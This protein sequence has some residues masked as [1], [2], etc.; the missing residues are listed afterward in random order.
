MSCLRRA[1]GTD[2]LGADENL[3][4]G[5]ARGIAQNGCSVVV[6]PLEVLS[7][8]KKSWFGVQLPPWCF[9]KR[10]VDQVTCFIFEFSFS[11]SSGAD[12]ARVP[13]EA[14]IARQ[15]AHNSRISTSPLVLAWA[16]HE[17]QDIYV[18]TSLGLNN[19]FLPW[20]IFT[21][22]PTVFAVQ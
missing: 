21:F 12:S 19:Q 7:R 9:L 6:I 22:A 20:Q 8:E 13:R 3:G 16:Q 1:S 5:L 11:S 10:C 4:L 2:V 17:E 18:P 14:T 15:S